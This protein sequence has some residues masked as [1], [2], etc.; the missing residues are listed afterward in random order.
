MKK[1]SKIILFVVGGILLAETIGIM[2]MGI[3]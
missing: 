1:R 3:K 2:K